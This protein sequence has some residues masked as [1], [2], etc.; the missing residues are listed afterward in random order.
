MDALLAALALSFAPQTL[1]ALTF[2]IFIGLIFGAI[3]GLTFTVALAVVLPITFALEPSAAIALLLGTY[4]GGMTGGMVSSILLGIPGT[5]SSAATVADGYQMTKNG[6]AS[7]ALGTTIIVS[8]FGGIFSLVVM[9]VSVDF[10]AGMA[11]KF[12]PAEIFALVLFGMSTIC[13]LAEKSLLRGLIA[14]ALGLM[15]MTIGLDE[16]DAT[17]RLTFGFTNMLQGV[18]L[19]V[20]MI[21]LFAVPHIIDAFITYRKGEQ[22]EVRASDV[23]IEFPS[24]QLLKSNFWLM[25]RCSAIGT[26]IGAIPGTG[27]PIATFIAYDHARRFSKHPE[28]FGKG[29]IE[30][31]IAPETTNNAVTGGTLIPLLSLGIPGDPAT[32]IV[33]SG[34]LI[35][36]LVPGPMLFVQHPA[37]IY[38]IYVVF[39]LSYILMLAIQIF[40][41]RA[42]VQV[43]R[44]P[45]HYLAVAII[46]MCG[47]GAFA[48]RNS[49]FDVYSMA[50]IGL[51]G[52]VL[53]RVQ[54]PVTPIIL[55]LVLGPTLEKNFRT[56][57]IL[58]EG[59][60]NIFT[61]PTA[62]LFFG[63]A[64]AVIGVQAW[65]SLRPKPAGNDVLKEE[66]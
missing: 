51:I 63:L 35:H 59:K 8:T 4:N 22:R 31:V 23:K 41:I 28:R 18:N 44:V 45:A 48:V 3:P 16:L 65:S 66:T 47:I 29:S 64:L 7:L 25:C 52:Y 20:A 26:G 46:V 14:G 2:G 10:V 30:G 32:A 53:L 12:G 36:G 38:T 1:A 60:L 58:S 34:L 37:Q 56:A 9:M 13:A 57:M 39:I 33:L 11:I 6:K 54:I 24:W 61:S 49:V 43:L 40:G 5:P 62:L 15:M 27:G 19:L 21:S 42:F 17:H 55:G 50:I